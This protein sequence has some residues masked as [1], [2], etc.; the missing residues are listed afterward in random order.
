MGLNCPIFIRASA[1]LMK[2]GESGPSK[3]LALFYNKDSIFT[4]LVS[5]ELFLIIQWVSCPSRDLNWSLPSPNPTLRP[6]NHMAPSMHILFLC[7]KIYIYTL[8]FFL[9]ETQ[10]SGH[11]RFPGS[12]PGRHWPNPVLLSFNMTEDH[13]LRFYVIHFLKNNNG[14]SLCRCLF[15]VCYS[16]LNPAPSTLFLWNYTF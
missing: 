4:R 11:R 16:F 15:S 9:Y 14:G 5:W 12:F 2:M 13:N 8:F 3:S 7:V 10:G 1:D 6:L